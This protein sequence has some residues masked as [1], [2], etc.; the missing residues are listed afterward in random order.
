VIEPLRMSF[1]VACSAEH[2]FATWTSRIDTWWPSDHTV[3]GEAGLLIVL[4]PGVG[5][6]IYERA[7]DGSEHEWGEVTVWEPPSRLAYLWHLRRDRRDATDV[8]IRF[9]ALTAASTRVEIEH[10]GWERLGDGAEDWRERNT[11]GWRTLLPHFIQATRGS[12]T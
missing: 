4:E 10:G 12:E 6:R 3:S 9:I 11:G 5:G 7:S 8:E 2:A 1:E